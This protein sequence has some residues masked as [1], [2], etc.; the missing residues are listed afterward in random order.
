MM[1]GSPSEV[2]ERY[3]ERS[4]INSVGD[5]RGRLLIV[6]G[7][8]DP[9]VT[10]ENV[11][12]VRKALDEA[13]IAYETLVFEDEGHGISRPRNQKVLC[14]RLLSFFEEAFGTAAPDAADGEGRG[15][16]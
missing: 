7:A 8:R 5:I 14:L 10:P 11:A 16:G 4:P 1:G 3:L 2:P 13:G 15:E 6:Q 9:N 12:A